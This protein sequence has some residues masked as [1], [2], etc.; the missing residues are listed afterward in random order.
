[1]CKS[2][3]IVGKVMITRL[4]SSAFNPVAETVIATTVFR[5]AFPISLLS[6][7]SLKT[8]GLT[9]RPSDTVE[10]WISAVPD[11]TFDGISNA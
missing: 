10:A 7:G 6:P 11:M 3:A 5:R 4:A 9:G 1:M 2:V 8:N